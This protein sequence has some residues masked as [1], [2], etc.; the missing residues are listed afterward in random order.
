[1][2]M[3]N[4]VRQTKA[5]R[6]FFQAKAANLLSRN[7]A[8]CGKHGKPFSTGKVEKAGIQIKQKHQI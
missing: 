5:K 4:K 1:M 6:D 8:G 3:K 7:A 2:S